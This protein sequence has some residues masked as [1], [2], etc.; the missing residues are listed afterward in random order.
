MT[1]QYESRR[2]PIFF[3]YAAPVGFSGQKEATELIVRGLAARGW[4]CRCL[5]QPVL[6]RGRGGLGERVRFGFGLL[7]AWLRS[8]R[9]LA[10]PGGSLCLNLGQTR[11]AFLRDG[12]PLVV[13]R[14]AFGRS[15]TIISLHGSLFMGWRDGSWDARLLRGLLRLAGTVTVLGE[16]QRSRLVAQGLDSAQV[17]VVVNSCTLPPISSDELDQ[18]RDSLTTGKRPVRLLHLSSLIATKGFPEY[19]EALNLLGGQKGLRIEATLCGRPTA[20]EFQ[21]RFRDETAAAAWIEGAVAAINHSA[22]VRVRWVRG[23]AGQEKAALFRAADVFV[24]PT[25]YAVEAQ[26]IVLLEAMASGCAI[27]T[28]SV[29]EIATILDEASAV[30]LRDG[31]TDELGATLAWLLAEPRTIGRLAGAAHQR[32]VERYGLAQHLDGW[33]DRLN[34]DR[35]ASIPTSGLA[36]TEP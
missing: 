36:A 4:N 27:V 8:L 1:S 28:T 23:A 5:P 31:A 16:Q 32:F 9:M 34:P 10:A 7:A 15:R 2:G 3:C 22:R 25:R 18:K 21:D 26:P 30:I 12:V 6:E 19:L 14:L 29:G 24:L 13:G 20:S 11:F 17:K 33:E 35:V